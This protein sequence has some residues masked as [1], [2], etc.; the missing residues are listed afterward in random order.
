MFL[1][2]VIAILVLSKWFNEK[3]LPY[4]KLD[5]KS[6]FCRKPELQNS[7]LCIKSGCIWGNGDLTGPPFCGAYK[8]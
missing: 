3:D 1:A 4:G 2:G 8:P 7:D 5:P 6:E